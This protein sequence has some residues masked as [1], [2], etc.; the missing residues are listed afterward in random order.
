MK[1]KLPKLPNFPNLPHLPRLNTEPVRKIVAFLFKHKISII[2]LISVIAFITVAMWYRGYLLSKMASTS[3]ESNDETFYST[4]TNNP[5][6][7]LVLPS[8]SDTNSS[9]LGASNNSGYNDNTLY[10]PPT[11]FPTFTPLPTIAPAPITT[12]TTT[13]TSSTSN[14]SG[15]PNCTTGSGVPNSWYSDVYPNPPVTTSTGSIDLIVDIRDCNKNDAPVSDKLNI[16]LSSGDPDTRIN[17]NKLPY[18]VT[19]QNGYVKFT[20]TSQAVGTVTLAIQDTTS[21]FA[22]T[23]INNDP[24]SIAFNAPPASTPSPAPTSTPTDTPTPTPSLSDTPTPTT[25]LSPS[26]T[27]TPTPTPGL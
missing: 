17:G 15:N 2:I 18:F 21:S 9:V 23:N 13:N 14:S 24:P 4:K 1:F 26:D 20:V 22:V 7:T 6:S 12:T 3:G 19:T 25:A 5:G 27:P 8:P 16:S 11:P 10:A